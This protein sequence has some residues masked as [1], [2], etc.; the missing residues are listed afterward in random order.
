[1]T[2]QR[3]QLDC[4][5]ECGCKRD[6]RRR[7]RAYVISISRAISQRCCRRRACLTIVYVLCIFL[8]FALVYWFGDLDF[9]RQMN[10]ERE[11]YLRADAERIS[12]PYAGIYACIQ[13]TFIDYTNM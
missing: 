13:A 8:R 1:M 12:Y 11:E 10:A 9:R 3:A 4:A 6:I 5:Y 2:A 7:Q